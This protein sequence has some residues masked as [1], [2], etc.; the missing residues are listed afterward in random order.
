LLLDL[1]ELPT[2]YLGVD[3]SADGEGLVVPGV[4]VAAAEAI[5]AAIRDLGDEASIAE[6]SNWVAEHYPGA[7]SAS[8]IGTD[9]ADLTY[10][11]SRSSLHS[12][13]ERFLR[14]GSRGRYRLRAR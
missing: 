13:N 1:P 9:M 12:N 14:E 7:F 10:P 4:N 6:V 11:G 5:R 2:D 8:T 3:W